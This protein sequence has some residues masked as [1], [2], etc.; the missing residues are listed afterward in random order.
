ML[1]SLTSLHQSTPFTKKISFDSAYTLIHK[2]LKCEKSGNK[3]LRE[4]YCRQCISTVEIPHTV[5]AGR[6]NKFTTSHT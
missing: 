1:T 3:N 2:V 6:H 5:T 4:S